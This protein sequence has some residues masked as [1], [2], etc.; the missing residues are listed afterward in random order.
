MSILRLSIT[1][2]PANPTKPAKASPPSTKSAHRN[3]L[4]LSRGFF[5]WNSERFD[6]FFDFVDKVGGAGPV[7]DAVVEGQGECDDL[8]GFVF[9]LAVRNHFA[10]CAADKERAD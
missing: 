3:G 5:R 1:C 7:D 4:G 8:G 9:L 6:Q 10:M 2:K